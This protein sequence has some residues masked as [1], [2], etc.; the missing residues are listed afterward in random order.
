MRI[1]TLLIVLAAAGTFS[2][3]RSVP[4]TGRTQLLLT[5]EAEELDLGRQAWRQVLSKERISKNKVY[6]KAVER[7]GANVAKAARKPEYNWEF[8]TF[9]SER[10]N[11]FCLPGGKIAV[12]TGLFKYVDNDAELATV[13]AHEVGHAIARHGGERVSEGLIQQAGAEAVA[14]SVDPKNKELALL[15]YGGATNVAAMLPYSRTH[16]YEA[17]H[18]G[19]MLM[20]E[21][22]Y[23][24]NYAISFWSKFAKASESNAVLELLQT[25]PMSEKRIQELKS[26]LPE[27]LRKYREAKIKH[28][29]GELIRG[30]SQP[31]APR[32]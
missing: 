21:A 18:I 28:G 16:E 24:P 29:R 5:S 13:M 4:Y 19:I 27:A 2:A 9:E 8:K 17:D 12:Y 6:K 14:A 31:H 3:C 10:A 20:A 25:H 11:A 1:H 23:D 30:N 26:L 32:P 7:V 22:G 15:I